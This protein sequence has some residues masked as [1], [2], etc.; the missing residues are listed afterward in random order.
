METKQRAELGVPQINR[1]GARWPLFCMFQIYEP[2]EARCLTAF[3]VE[4]ELRPTVMP[5]GLN[6]RLQ[7]R[8][9]AEGEL[10]PA[11]AGLAKLCTLG[12]GCL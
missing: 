12:G 5:A 3:A 1:A 8:W 6:E 11:F 9:R 2:T 10:L 4:A 7:P